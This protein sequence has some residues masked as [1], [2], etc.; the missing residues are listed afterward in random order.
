M[1]SVFLCFLS[2]RWR[3]E[4]FIIYY[5]IGFPILV[6]GGQTS[7]PPNHKPHSIEP[8]GW[9]SFNLLRFH[10][11]GMCWIVYVG[12]IS[13]SRVFPA[14]MTIKYVVFNYELGFHQH[15]L[16][17]SG[18]ERSAMWASHVNTIISLL[19]GVTEHITVFNIP[20][21]LHSIQ[22]YKDEQK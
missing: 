11:S 1:D 13:S 8:G 17:T 14:L 4:N 22:A 5:V 9:M 3:T 6:S 10:S 20:T 16:Y 12:R 15:L 18:E 21:A 19:T 7:Y 2:S